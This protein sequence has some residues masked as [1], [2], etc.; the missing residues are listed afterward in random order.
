MYIHTDLSK[1]T[2]TRDLL[3]TDCISKD[4]WWS[5]STKQGAFV[6]FSQA[7]LCQTCQTSKWFVEWTNRYFHAHTETFSSDSWHVFPC[8]AVSS[9]AWGSLPFHLNKFLSAALFRMN[10]GHQN[11]QFRM[12]GWCLI[13]WVKPAREQRIDGQ[14]QFLIFSS[15]SSLYVDHSEKIWHASVQD[16]CLCSRN[17]LTQSMGWHSFRFYHLETGNNV[18]EQSTWSCCSRSVQPIERKV[19]KNRHSFLTFKFL[20]KLPLSLASQH[21]AAAV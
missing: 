11:W 1:C 21:G 19:L 18:K 6:S 14:Y 4:A 10:Q 16:M 5:P 15:L 7:F 12:S 13:A 17:L 8:S 2:R 9:V 3:G 20:V